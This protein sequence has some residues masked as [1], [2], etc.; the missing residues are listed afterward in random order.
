MTRCQDAVVTCPAP[1]SCVSS[2]S[3]STRRPGP[4]RMR[5]PST[6]GNRRASPC[7]VHASPCTPVHAPPPHLGVSEVEVHHE[8]HL[9]HLPP[10]RPQHHRQPGTAP[11]PRRSPS[12]TVNGQRS[13]VNG[14]RSTI[15]GQRSN[16]NVQTGQRSTSRPAP[17]RGSS[18]AHSPACHRGGRTRCGSAS[19][20]WQRGRAPR[21]RPAR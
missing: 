5:M 10:Q 16:V 6:S 18:P 14:Q 2:G 12:P 7:C 9:S 21:Q 19:T 15:N 4:G 1:P 11:P 3:G 17:P 20:P 13:T 8:E